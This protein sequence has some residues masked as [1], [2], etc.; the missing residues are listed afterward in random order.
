VQAANDCTGRLRRE[1]AEPNFD[2]Q[3]RYPAFNGVEY[4]ALPIVARKSANILILPPGSAD[5]VSSWLRRSSQL[6]ASIIGAA[7]RRDRARGQYREC[8]PVA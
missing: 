7:P 2:F 4:R 5:V 1:Q 3:F 8:R 6:P